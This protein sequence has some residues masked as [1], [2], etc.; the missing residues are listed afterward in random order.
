[1]IAFLKGSL[2]ARLQD[3]AIIEV[4]GMGILVGMSAHSLSSLPNVGETVQVHTF[5]QVREYA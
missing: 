2:A 1:M 3:A 4:G 5:L